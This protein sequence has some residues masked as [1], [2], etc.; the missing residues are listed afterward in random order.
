M[1]LL[2]FETLYIW[3]TQVIR[4]SMPYLL[5][6]N[7]SVFCE[8]SGVINIALEGIM[9]TSAL[10]G[11][12]GAF[13]SS[14]PFIGLT[15]GVICGMIISALLG[16]MCV[17]LNVDQIIAGLGVNLLSIGLTRF[18]LKTLFGSSSNSPRI[19]GFK[20]SV[21]FTDPIFYICLILVILLF[22]FF[23]LTAFGL[24]VKAVGE[25]PYAADSLGIK[26]KKIRFISVIISGL[27]AGIGGCWLSFQQ[28]Q[29]TDLMTSGRGYIA[30]T[31]VIF[32]RWSPLGA[33]LASI[34]FG[35]AETVEIQL[36]ISG[37]QIPSQFIQMIPYLLTIVVICGLIGKT[38]P[39]KASGIPFIKG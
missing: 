3:F 17:Y 29:F 5:A 24:K 18:V 7:G 32:G 12:V 9:L 2:F 19:E 11:V 27:M 33:T 22:V 16:F 26:V 31:A 8:K 23:Y 30:L 37:I 38:S 21:I 13:F 4:I 35:L 36:Q 14:N 15:C 10:G 25:N 39:P 20:S 34:F 1:N 28:H 6:S